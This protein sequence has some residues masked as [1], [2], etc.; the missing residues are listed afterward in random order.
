[1]PSLL[2]FLV[3]CAVLAG[4]VYGGMFALVTMVEPNHR[5]MTVRIPA[6]KLEPR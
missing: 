6:N 4:I 1:M 3:I 5:E 2:R